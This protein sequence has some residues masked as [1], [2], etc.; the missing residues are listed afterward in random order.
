MLNEV[1]INEVIIKRKT[2]LCQREANK[3]W[4]E[5]NREHFNEL[6]RVNNKKYHKTSD[7]FKEGNK[8]RSRLYYEEN[9][10]KILQR[11]KEYYK[12]KKSNIR[13]ES[14]TI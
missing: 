10:E 11:Q 8:L 3:K 6:C 2:P 12:K 13:N 1:I 7:K 14:Q 5:N 9:K 4:V